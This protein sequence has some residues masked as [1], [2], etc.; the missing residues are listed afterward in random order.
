MCGILG[1]VS[2]RGPVDEAVF[3][4]MRDTLIHRGP[5]GFDSWFSENRKIALGHRRLTLLDLTESGKQPMTNEDGTIWLTFN[6]EIY[7]YIELK[8]ELE[9]FGHVFKSTT[10]TEVIIHGFEQWGKDMINKLK[11]MFAF[12]LWNNNT[13]KLFIARDRFG[14]KPLYYYKSNKCFIFASEIK[15]IIKN[16]AVSREIDFSSMSDYL[17][18]R[19]VP[20]PGTIWKNIKKLPP[21]QFLELD[22]TGHEQISEYWKIQFGSNR[23]SDKK[24]V[25]KVD[26]LLRNSVATH[27]RCD[28][29]VGSF[30]SG[31]YDSS[32]MVYY[33]SCLNYNPQTFSIGFEGWK[34]SEHQY[35]E[36]VANHFSTKHT[37]TMIGPES[38]D[39]LEKL[40]TVY[41]EPLADISIVPTYMVSKAASQKVK[42]V[43]SGEGADELFCGYS[44]HYAL[45][46]TNSMVSN[47]LRLKALFT[48]PKNNYFVNQYAHAMAMGSFDRQ[49]ISELLNPDLHTFTPDY[50]DWFYAKNYKNNVSTI[51]AFQ[52]MD[53]KCFM[54]ELVLTKIDR[55]SM[56]NSLEVRVP[57]LDHELYE[58]VLGLDDSVYF[59]PGEKKYLLRENIK[60]HLP[61]KIINRS[62]QGFVG[63][64]SYYMNIEWY[65]SKI[66]GGRLL[67]DQII[68]SHKVE[69]L[70]VEK[71]H[72]RL[73][74]ILVLEL[75]Y[76]KWNGSN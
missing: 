42:T 51:K 21:A 26:E 69:K 52:N 49:N 47:L 14:I 45:S 39:I 64:D 59:K 72:W 58:F 13:K 62:K 37:S 17:T 76:A 43:L 38:L 16:P 27:I 15:A 46:N 54:G 66:R 70:I 60:N 7:N 34:E 48:S 73:W 56:A 1:Q 50:S 12:G 36:M 75:W 6:G 33:L 68:N 32:A 20:S 41:D 11:G 55:A 28:V 5:D 71:D 23:I 67:S 24:A 30:L 9:S 53:I 29:P 18:Y 35:A 4:S 3:S 44:W 25:D 40:A 19:Y 2:F 65:A 63:P 31:G 57:F 10:D 22:V 61:Q 74:K 8:K